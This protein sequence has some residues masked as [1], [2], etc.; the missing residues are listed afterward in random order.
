MIDP[1][2]FHVASNCLHDAEGCEIV[3]ETRRNPASFRIEG[4][5]NAK[6]LDDRY[7]TREHVG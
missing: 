1:N 4:R 3:F 5:S 7:G 6:L 2:F